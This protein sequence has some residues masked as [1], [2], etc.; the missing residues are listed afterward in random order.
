MCKE[1]INSC[2]EPHRPQ[3]RRLKFRVLRVWFPPTTD[4]ISV[5]KTHAA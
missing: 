1:D 2:K 3:V 4:D 5:N